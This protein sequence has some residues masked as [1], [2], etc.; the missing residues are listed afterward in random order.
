MA[1]SSSIIR[2][3]CG[4]ALADRNKETPVLQ[5]YGLY[6][7]LDYTQTRTEICYFFLWL[8]VGRGA[9]YDFLRQ[10][11]TRRELLLFLPH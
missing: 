9:I 7:A 3:L 10:M 6:M 8:M 1:I 4:D 2:G 5:I 11:A